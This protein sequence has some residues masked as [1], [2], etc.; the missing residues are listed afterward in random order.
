MLFNIKPFRWRCGAAE[1]WTMCWVVAGRRGQPLTCCTS[2]RT[3]D[4]NLC[5]DFLNAWRCVAKWRIRCA[6]PLWLSCWKVVSWSG[7]IS[8]RTVNK[9]FYVQHSIL[10]GC[11]I[12]NFIN[13]CHIM[14]SYC[15]MFTSWPFIYKY[16]PAD[17]SQQ[18]LSWKGGVLQN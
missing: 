17:R 1:I 4:R 3:P 2:V 10:N 8:N 12:F 14:F 9:N 16:K 13:V 5:L 18:A 7:G 15:N 6:T 11:H